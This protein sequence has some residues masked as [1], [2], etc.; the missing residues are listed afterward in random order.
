[1]KQDTIITK[2]YYIG[3][4]TKLCQKTLKKP[5]SWKQRYSLILFRRGNTTYYCL[6]INVDSYLYAELNAT[7]LICLFLDCIWNGTIKMLFNVNVF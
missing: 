3:F 1:M 7:F 4:L 2:A 6:K 5:T